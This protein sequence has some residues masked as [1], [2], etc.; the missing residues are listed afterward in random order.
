MTFI[1]R[2]STVDVE[3]EAIFITPVGNDVANACI[4]CRSVTF[5]FLKIPFVKCLV[6][7]FWMRLLIKKYSFQQ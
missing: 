7:V 6:F 4:L 1:Y 2:W 3:V 5:T